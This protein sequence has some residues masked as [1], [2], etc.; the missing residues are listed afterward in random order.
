M[1]NGLNQWFIFAGCVPLGNWAS[2]AGLSKAVSFFLRIGCMSDASLCQRFSFGARIQL[3]RSMRAKQRRPPNSPKEHFS[4]THCL[5][6]HWMLERRKPPEIASTST[7]KASL[8]LDPSFE[9]ARKPS[10]SLA[11]TQQGYACMGWKQ[12]QSS[13]VL[14]GVHQDLERRRTHP[15]EIF[16]VGLEARALNHAM[17]W[18]A[19]M[20]VTLS[21]DHFRAKSW[22]M[23]V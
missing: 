7:T 1:D 4:P 17:Q 3:K 21:F 5:G 9:A 8:D 11:S 14:L 16:G 12:H 15:A 13:A 2:K 10:L 23:L 18:V 20:A 19:N 22:R 6:S